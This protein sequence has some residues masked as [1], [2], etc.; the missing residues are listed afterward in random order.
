M[1]R[2][3]VLNR[4]AVTTVADGSSPGQPDT[5]S[6]ERTRRRVPRTNPTP[7]SSLFRPGAGP[8]EI[9]PLDDLRPAAHPRQGAKRGQPPGRGEARGGGVVVR[10]VEVHRL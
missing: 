10:Y 7:S 2:T 9:E 6:P 5:A 1:G 8:D 3:E 4:R